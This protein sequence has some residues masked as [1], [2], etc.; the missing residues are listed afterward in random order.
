MSQSGIRRL[1]A[2]MFADMVG[3]TAL[4]Q[5]DEAAA[6]ARRDRHRAVL[7]D[8]VPRH[9]G[10]ILQHYGDGTLSVFDSAVEAVEC[11]IAIQAELH[12][13]PQV[14]LRIGV[15]SGD[16]VRDADGVYGDGVNVASRIESL[17]A[18]GGVLVS[19]KIYDEIKN[20]PSVSTTYLG[21]VRLKNVKQP[22]KVYAI[23]NP[24]LVVPSADEIG[25]K[26]DVSLVP[27]TAGRE[28][29]PVAEPL[30]PGE[31]FL[32]RARDR[33]ML[34][35]A[36]AYL[37]GAWASLEI[38][39]FM[40]QLNG[41]PALV[42]R[43]FAVLAF[44]GF[45]VTLV[46]TWFHG[47]RGRQRIRGSEVL[48]IALVLLMAGGAITLL[49]RNSGR[50]G[51]GA[52]AIDPP[53]IV[54]NRPSV[55]VLPFDN[56]SSEAENAYFASGLH[57]EVITQLLR[58]SGLRVISRTSVMEYATNRPNVR[59]IGRELGVTHITEASVQRDGNRLRVNVQLIDARTD[60]HLWAMSWDRQLNDAFA[61]QSEVARVIADS[62]TTTLTAE[63]RGA[64]S[65][66][67]TDDPEAYRFYLQGRDY[68]LRPGYRQ[69]NY[70]AA[71]RL[72][73]RAIELDPAFAL[74]HAI[75]SRVHGH[76]YWENFDATPNRLAKQETEVDEALRL[77]PAL[78][79]A[80]VSAG[81][82]H[83]VRG[84]FVQALSEYETALRG[85]P[86]DAEIVARIGYTQRRLDNWP[87][88]F[89]AYEHATELNPR[90]ATLFYDLGGHS[91]AATRRYADAVKAYDQALALAPDLYDAAIRK[92]FVF[93]HWR[94]QLDTLQAVLA[95]IPLDRHLPEVDLAR[96]D[97]AFW[98]RDADALLRV[99]EET[100][101]RVFETQL[102]FLPKPLYSA[103]AYGL[104]GDTAAARA[105]FTTARDMLE[106]LVR[107]RPN[108]ARLV[109]ALGFVQAGLGMRTEA[110]ASA[111]RS[112]Q[113]GQQGGTASAGGG[114]S[115]ETAA[116]IL[117]Q[118]GLAG[119]TVRQLRGLLAGN[120]SVSVWTLRRNPLLDPIR[121]D[122]GFRALVR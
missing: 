75:L 73:E 113:L 97:L 66:P 51:D 38:V 41:W 82:L 29:A 122:P 56:M 114:Q 9:R 85:L 103:W 13:P 17:A 57:D 81:W 42:Q 105:A 96:A 60:D 83:Y 99:L 2:I 18:T 43:S 11:A 28:V 62:L 64:I 121:D 80:H 102:V 10:E 63:E 76:M 117:A 98:Q 55:A 12:Q 5:E 69:E 108:D 32:Q 120:S 25:A 107:L 115:A 71:E 26:A 46:V 61:V 110:A 52:V 65:T 15:H 111:D 116:A 20:H 1:A 94:G 53:P 33:A 21:E 79:Q 106:P 37:A 48:I 104:R 27:M 40:T 91:F 72:F 30:G 118:A 59:V 95:R 14:E 109:A 87:A 86:N 16:I 47:E 34:P 45:F 78:P 36:L 49:R 112:F 92:G 101:G 67:P 54:D 35:W 24:G 68:Y 19:G 50:V 119:E 77:Q 39:G 4:M 70:L 31:R 23:T 93:L 22:V 90:N 44:A 6:R 3:Y 74:A 89:E 100:P 84:E 88:V 58:V 7:S 8:L